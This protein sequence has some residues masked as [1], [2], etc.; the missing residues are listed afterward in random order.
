MYYLVSL[1]NEA[2]VKLVKHSPERS[3]VVQRNTSPL[4]VANLCISNTSLPLDVTMTRLDHR[5]TFGMERVVGVLQILSW[6]LE[7]TV[8]NISKWKLLPTC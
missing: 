3:D 4:Q 8:T 5:L 2:A 6:I 1:H 7:P